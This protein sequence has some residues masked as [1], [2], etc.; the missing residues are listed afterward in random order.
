MIPGSQVTTDLGIG[1]AEDFLNSAMWHLWDSGMFCLGLNSQ[2]V[3]NVLHQHVLGALP[4][5]TSLRLITFPS[6]TNAGIAIALRPQNPPTIHVGTGSN[7]D[8]PA[9]VG[10]VPFTGVGLLC[11][12]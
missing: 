2:H 11:V 1:V 10:V 9:Y 8:R 4:G 6:R 12:E 7:R 5:L 3:A